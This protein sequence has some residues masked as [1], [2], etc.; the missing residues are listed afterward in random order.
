M[1]NAKKHVAATLALLSLTNTFAP[2]PFLDVSPKVNASFFSKKDFIVKSPIEYS[3]FKK[4]LE[5]VKN[6]IPIQKIPLNCR[7]QQLNEMASKLSLSTYE[8]KE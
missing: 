1:K 7:I 5:E 3:E 2:A 4:T 6:D 8:Q